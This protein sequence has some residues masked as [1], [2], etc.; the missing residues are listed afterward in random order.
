M[1]SLQLALAPA[2]APLWSGLQA[3]RGNARDRHLYMMQTVADKHLGL[4]AKLLLI[5]DDLTFIGS[6]NLDPRSLHLNTEM[7]I[8]VDSRELNRLVRR[9]IALDFSKRNPWHLQAVADERIIWVGLFV[10][11]ISIASQAWAIHR[12]VDYWQTVVFTVLTVSQLFHSLAVRTESASLFR[13]ALPATCRCS[14]PYSSP[15]CCSSR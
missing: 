14:A 2:D 4:H 5:D 3:V 6:A 15:S 7:G 13:G 9:N 10:G 11:G 8:L 1:A 12:G